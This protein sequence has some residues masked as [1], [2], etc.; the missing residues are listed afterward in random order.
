MV[1]DARSVCALIVYITLTF[2]GGKQLS[3]YIRERMG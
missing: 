2:H 3:S 1:N